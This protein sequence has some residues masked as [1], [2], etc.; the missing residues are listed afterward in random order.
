MKTVEL[1]QSVL[2]LPRDAQELFYHQLGERLGVGQPAMAKGPGLKKASAPAPVA[3]P[4]KAAA[5]ALVPAPIPSASE[6]DAHRGRKPD[7]NS[8]AG[9]VRDAV[10]NLL[11][12]NPAGV[13]IKNHL[14]KLAKKTGLDEETIKANWY[15][16]PGVSRNEGIWKREGK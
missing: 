3:K 9:K 11:D 7:P 14:P 15:T 2:S 6:S 12:Q 13:A 1:L 16:I 4:Q 8:N 5:L 10:M